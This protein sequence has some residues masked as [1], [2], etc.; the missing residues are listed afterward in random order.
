MVARI[1]CYVNK[2]MSAYLS[3]LAE[4]QLQPDQ[5]DILYDLPIM[6]KYP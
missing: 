4:L 3:F 1:P 5:N 2:K 6:G